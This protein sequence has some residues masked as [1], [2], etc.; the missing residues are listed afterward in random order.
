[1][2]TNQEVNRARQRRFLPQASGLILL[3][4]LICAFALTSCV[5]EGEPEN[6]GVKTGD[7]LPA[8]SVKLN[9]GREMTTASLRGKRV[10]IE[11]FNTEC[12]DCRES[13]PLINE[14]YETLKDNPDVEIFAVARAEDASKL[15]LYWAEN[16]LT[17]PYSPQDDRKVYELFATVGIPRIYVA[18]SSG[19]ITAAFGPEDNPTLPQ[20]INLLTP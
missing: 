18:D 3:L 2:E 19:V 12:P 9:D 15:S 4:T 16:N 17:L 5:A 20:L 7:P 14:L 8:F 1:M 10:L 11:L 13:L 6:N